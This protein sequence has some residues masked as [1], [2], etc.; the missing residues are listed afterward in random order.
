[1]KTQNS[2]PTTRQCVHPGCGPSRSAQCSFD[3]LPSFPRPDRFRQLFFYASLASAVLLVA[4]GCEKHEAARSQ[5]EQRPVDVAATT[6]EPRDVP[7]T[8]EYIAQVQSSRQVNIQARVNGFLDK[9]VYTEGAMVDEGQTLFVMDQK[10]FKVQ[11]QQAEAALARQQAAF[12]VAR[13]NLARVKPLAAAN[14]L[15]QKDLD[16]ATGQYQSTAAA[17]E[18]AK[19]TVEQAKLNLSYTVIASPVAGITSSAEQADG[20]YLS[21]S[22]SQLTTVTVL[23]PAYV[24][25]SISENEWLQYRDQI[26]NKLLI[27]PKDREYVAEVVLADG[28]IYPHTGKVTFAAPSFNAQ[29]GTFLIRATLENPDGLLRPNQYVRVRLKGAIRPNAILVP[30]RAVQQSSKGH[31]VWVVDK[32][33]KAEQR[34]VVVGEWQE[35]EWIIYEG[36]H[37]GDRVVV[38]GTLPLRPGTSLKVSPQVEKSGQ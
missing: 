17:V 15:S 13:Q 26:A 27:V 1:M 18:Q 35:N 30:Q 21:P 3:R 19:A 4:F 11:L 37:P 6:V 22:N 9:R 16:D 20:T 34:P 5:Q 28:S 10:P 23:S 12:E 8:F 38:D 14:A 29:T 31:F 36:L 24:N 32:E 33:S 7:I 25:F 2:H